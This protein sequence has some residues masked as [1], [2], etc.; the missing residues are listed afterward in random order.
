MTR[1]DIN[2]RFAIDPKGKGQFSMREFTTD[3]YWGDD[4][5]TVVNDPESIAIVYAGKPFL[6]ESVKDRREFVQ[7]L[8]KLHQSRTVAPV[9]ASDK[10]ASPAAPA[11]ASVKASASSGP[12]LDR[13]KLAPKSNA[14]EKL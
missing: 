3:F 5:A 1:N 9:K 13:N 2:V 14:F 11:K 4:K 12:V 6:E 8:L 10:A 7:M